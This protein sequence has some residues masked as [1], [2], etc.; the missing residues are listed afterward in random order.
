ML[1]VLEHGLDSHAAMVGAL[2]VR[3][4][5]VSWVLDHGRPPSDPVVAIALS[6]TE[7]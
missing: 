7:S 5:C 6:L 1:G 2:L 4:Q 3:D